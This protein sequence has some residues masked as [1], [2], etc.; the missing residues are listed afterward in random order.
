MSHIL[1]VE[2]DNVLAEL[3]KKLFTNEGHAVEIARDGEEGLKA[4]LEKDFQV[5][6]LDILMPNMDGV[7][8]LKR[9]RREPKGKNVPVV[10]LTN[11]ADEE[12]REKTLELDA[13]EYLV[14]AI[15]SP[16]EVARIVKKYLPNNT[17]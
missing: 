12:E 11:Q 13:K 7:E 3:Y 6:L 16:E 5:I 17:N 10:I 8:M 9:L 14:K 15:Q 4:A 1:I 2:D